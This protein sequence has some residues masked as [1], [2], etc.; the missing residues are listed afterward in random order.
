MIKAT[1]NQLVNV[2]NAYQG[3]KP[4]ILF[5]CSAGILR[6]PTAAN[7][8]HKELGLNT[9]ACGSSKD[10]ALIPISEAL[11]QWAD[12][13]VFVNQDNLDD[14]D[15]EEKD[16]ISCLDKIISVLNVPDEHDWGS[17]ELEYAIFDQFLARKKKIIEEF[18][19]DF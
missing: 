16:L 19:D 5:V 11:I 13:I 9:R 3:K 14:L 2:S 6:S 8:I 18:S 12:E 4:K 1:R 7:K 15:K 17:K 10:F